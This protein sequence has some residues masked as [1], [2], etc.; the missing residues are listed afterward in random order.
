[1]ASPPTGSGRAAVGSNGPT[2]GADGP[3]TASK[4]RNARSDPP[5]PGSELGR[6]PRA[7]IAALAAILIMGAAVI[8]ISGVHTKV[9]ELTLDLITAHKRYPLDLIGAI[10]N[11]LGFF[12]AASTLSFLFSAIR[13][14]NPAAQ[15][16]MRVLAV[17]GG[18]VAGV[19]GVVYAVVIADKAHTFVTTG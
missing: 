2:G 7:A 9:N 18:V 5:A 6:L 3:T 14:R 11:A 13:A 10:V 19:V 8:Q 16:F 12:A 1:M 15:P 17:A 4:R